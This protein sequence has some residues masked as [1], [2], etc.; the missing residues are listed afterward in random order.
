MKTENSMPCYKVRHWPYREPALSNS[1]PFPV[2]S[3]VQ[4][5]YEADNSSPSSAEGK[6]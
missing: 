2:L 1:L 4:S 5:G 6:E 3:I